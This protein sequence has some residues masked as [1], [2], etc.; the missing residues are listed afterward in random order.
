MTLS[1]GSEIHRKRSG[2]TIKW[3]RSKAVPRIQLLP[4]SYLLRE[5][6]AADNV[7]IKIDELLKQGRLL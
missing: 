7:R 5:Q 6:L 2:K 4:S 1:R 3:D